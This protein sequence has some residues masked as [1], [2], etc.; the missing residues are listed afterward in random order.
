MIPRT[1]EEWVTRNI[2]HRRIGPGESTDSD[3]ELGC[4]SFLAKMPEKTG[5]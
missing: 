5:T 2:G 3:S 1:M 4:D